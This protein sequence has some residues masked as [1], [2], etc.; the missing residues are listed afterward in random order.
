MSRNDYTKYARESKIE[1]PE[2]PVENA[3]V[4]DVSIENESVLD[5]TDNV[6]FDTNVKNVRKIGHVVGCTR[7]NVR[8][9]PNIRANVMC[10]IECG[11]EVEIDDNDSTLDFYKILTASG[12]EGYCVKKY[13][14]MTSEN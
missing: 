12:V 4:K 14:S 8:K 1:S 10:E 5:V 11:S 7:L 9:T 13:I 3:E 6:E 2:I